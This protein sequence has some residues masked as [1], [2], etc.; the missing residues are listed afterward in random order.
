M[1]HWV[2]EVCTFTGIHQECL[3]LSEYRRSPETSRPRVNGWYTRWF[4]DCENIRNAILFWPIQFS[5]PGEHHCLKTAGKRP[6][7]QGA[8][9]LKNHIIESMAMCGM[10]F[11]VVIVFMILGV[12]V[13]ER[14]IGGNRNVIDFRMMVMWYQVM[15]QES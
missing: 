3:K 7:C 9:F 5:P 10:L 1:K 8:M 12:T 14:T 15:S 11:G 2:H 4:E 13:F 6:K